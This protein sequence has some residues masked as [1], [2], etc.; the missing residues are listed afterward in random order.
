MRVGVFAALMLAAN[1][2]VAQGA[3]YDNFNAGIQLYNL[4]EWDQ[5][6]ARFDAA[7]AANDLAP[8]LQF[9]AH[10]DRGQSHM[11]LS[12][13]DQAIQDYSAGL[14]LRPGEVPALVSRSIAYAD[15]GKLDQA[16][17][18]LDSAI[19]VRPLLGGSYGMRASLHIKRGEPEKAL[20]DM[21]TM[22]KLLPDTQGTMIGISY[23]VTGQIDNA[24][25]NFSYVTDRGP[26]KIYAWL[27]YAL[28]RVRLGKTVPRQLLPDLDEKAW[29]API[30]AFFLGKATQDSVFAAAGQG[31]TKQL[32]G[33]LCEANFYTGEWLLQHHDEAA[34]KP[35]LAK[36]ASDCPPNFIEWMPAQMDQAA[37]P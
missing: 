20:D 31:D 27:W 25:K 14:T 17:A 22:L 24:E 23:W 2:A 33:Q 32:E 1:V 3:S 16:A 29:P 13:Y 10:F 4:G 9:I 5:A 11:A 35:L 28:A 7:L 26:N 15:A 37:L 19:A 18:D 6:I 8:S 21:R 34:A 36:A 12:Q 30:V